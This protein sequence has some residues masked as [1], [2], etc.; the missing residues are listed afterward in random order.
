V[1]RWLV[2][3]AG[4]YVLWCALLWFKQ[5]A[6]IFPRH[7]TAPG[8]PRPPENAEAWTYSRLNLGDETAIEAWFFLGDGCSREHPG[9]AVM[10]FHGN[11]DLIDHWTDVAQQYTSRGVSVLLCEFRGYGRS[12]GQPSQSAI[13]DDACRFHDMLAARPEVRADAI[14]AH[15]RSLGGGV[16][17]Q[18]AANKPIT[19]LILDE[20]F[21]SVASFAASYGVPPF[22]VKHPFRTDDALSAFKGR[23]FIAHGTRDVTVPFSHGKKLAAMRPDATF[24]Q[25]PCDHFSFPGDSAAYWE[26]LDEF[27]AHCGLTD[28]APAPGGP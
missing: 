18:L 26:A 7:F 21:T 13:V 9:P 24:L 16:A 11:A 15:G 22:L 12:G 28:T 25:L 10:I 1:R 3:L 8:M 5:D 6:M 2:V 27:L 19:A 4:L 14:L 20:T 17:A 23:V